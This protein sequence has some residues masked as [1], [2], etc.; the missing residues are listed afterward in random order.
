MPEAVRKAGILLIHIPKNAGT[1]LSHALYGEDIG[2]LS[3]KV[4]TARYPHTVRRMATCAVIRDPVGRFISAFHFLKGGGLTPQ[5][6]EF[7]R[8]HLAR[9]DSPESLV[10]AMSDPVVRKGITSYY[11]FIPQTSFLKNRHG[12]LAVKIL[13]PYSR[14]S[15]EEYL[16]SVFGWEFSLPCLN[17]TQRPSG[18]DTIT[19]D[20]A[21]LIRKYYAEDQR[22]HVSLASECT[23][24]GH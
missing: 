3:L 17:V 10:E 13:I 15:D 18:S 23:S 2:H 14:L 12:H 8:I 20:A 9:H 7:S 4:W 5:D 22:L 16:K 11:H 19:E 21:N 6:A 24:S 1:S